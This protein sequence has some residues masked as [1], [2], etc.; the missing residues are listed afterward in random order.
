MKN[1][2]HNFIYKEAF[3]GEWW[4]IDGQAV[5][6]D[7]DIVDYN[8]SGVALE[9]II[10]NL[11]DE[12]ND[13][14]KRKNQRIAYE[15]DSIDL[16]D[17]S[18]QELKEAGFSDEE[19][20]AL[21][22]PREYAM[23]YMGWIRV[24]GR[25]VQIWT[26]SSKGLK[27]IANGLWDAVGGD[28]VELEEFNIETFQ[29]SAAYRDIPFKIIEQGDPSALYE[30]GRRTNVIFASKTNNLTRQPISPTIIV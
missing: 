14:L 23:K 2:Y 20:K 16:D 9:H 13:I 11:L 28:E 27:I 26:L 25:N 30:Y 19:I 1:W 6:A 29:P 10:S 21:P 4:I 15:P 8:H 18:P 3:T 24:Q 22:D 7:G 5:F 12:L 17:F